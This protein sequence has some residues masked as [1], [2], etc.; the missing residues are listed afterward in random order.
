MIGKKISQ[1]INFYLRMIKKIQNAFFRVRSYVNYYCNTNHHQNFIKPK[2]I[3]ANECFRIY[4]QYINI[5]E[6]VL[7]RFYNQFYQYFTTRF[8]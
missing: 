5:F 7:H 6:P 8:I 3:S 2:M 1:N 4:V